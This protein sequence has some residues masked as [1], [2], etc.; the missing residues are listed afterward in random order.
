MGTTS[1]EKSPEGSS[2]SVFTYI[3]GAEIMSDEITT[4]GEDENSTSVNDEINSEQGQ[5]PLREKFRLTGDETIMKDVKPSI[6]A[7]LPM[8]LVAGLIPALT[9]YLLLIGIQIQRTTF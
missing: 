4:A 3:L 1:L 7:F 8:Y 6:F 9:S 5:N 2:S